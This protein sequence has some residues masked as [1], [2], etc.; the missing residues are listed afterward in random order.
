MAVLAVVV[1]QVPEDGLVADRD[2]RFR[3]ALRIFANARTETATE[4]DDLHRLSSLGSTIQG[5]GIGTMKRPP[6][7]A[8][9]FIWATISDWRFQ[10]RIST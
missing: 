3:N 7:S 1:H 10:G 5:V 2:H 4:Q 8:M 6:Q 9:C